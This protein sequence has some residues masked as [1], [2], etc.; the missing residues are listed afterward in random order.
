LLLQLLLLHVRLLVY[1]S[2][3]QLYHF[4]Q[5]QQQQ[6]EMPVWQHMW[7]WPAVQVLTVMV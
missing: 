1:C 7:D 6:G 3:Q 2:R 5:Q 4:Q